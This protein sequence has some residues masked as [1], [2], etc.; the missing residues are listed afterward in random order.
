MSAPIQIRDP[1]LTRD[2]R[3]HALETG[4][5]LTKTIADAIALSREQAQR[6]KHEDLAA[7]R[8]AVEATI[9]RIRALPDIGP[10]LTDDDL[11]DEDGLPK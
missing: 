11:Y 3:D 7:R 8:A 1:E 10:R 2:I 4:R 5:S 6:Q 9:A